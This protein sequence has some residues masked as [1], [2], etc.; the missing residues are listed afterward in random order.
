MRRQSAIHLCVVFSLVLSLAACDGSGSGDRADPPKVACAEDGEYACK[1]GA[2]EPLYTFQWALNYADSY[3][4]AYPD[5]FGD[6]LDLNVEPVHRLGIKGQGVRVLV[7]DSGVDLH[8]PDLAPNADFGMSHNM[9]DDTNDPYPQRGYPDDAPHGTNVAGMIAAAQNG[10]GVMGIAPRVVLG[11]VNYLE[12]QGVASL[13]ASLGG[14]PWSSQVDIFNGSYGN[15][16]ALYSYDTQTDYQTPVVRAIKNYEMA[17]GLYFLRPP[18]MILTENI[19]A[20]QGRLFTIVVIRAMMGAG[21]ANLMS[22]W[23]LPS[24]LLV[25]PAIT[26]A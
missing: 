1:T 22:W 13:V 23:W 11:G 2:T 21:R 26:A 20:S 14:A 9:V 7:V 25:N 18:V 17:K 12:N 5:V 3:F 16:T 19:A 24:M 8:S 10:Q 6:G 4:N 15:S